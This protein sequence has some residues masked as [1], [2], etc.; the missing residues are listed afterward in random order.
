MRKRKGGSREKRGEGD[1]EEIEKEGKYCRR[2]KR[3][4]G[5]RDKKGERD[6]KRRMRREV[7]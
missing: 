4:R 6:I 5:S 7:S 2:R 3:K 1:E